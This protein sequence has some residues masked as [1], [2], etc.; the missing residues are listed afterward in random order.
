[1]TTKNNLCTQ[2][3]KNTAAPN[4]KMCSTC[5]EKSIK[6]NKKRLNFLLKQGLCTSCGKNPANAT[7]LLCSQCRSRQKEL[8][9]QRYSKRLSENLCIS[10]GSKLTDL[11]Y[12][13]CASCRVKQVAEVKS[14]KQCPEC[15][16]TRDI[17]SPSIRVC[18]DCWIKGRQR[19]LKANS[20]ARY[21]GNLEQIIDRDKECLIC[22]RPYGTRKNKVV[23]HHIDNNENNNDPS[24]LILLCRKCHLLATWWIECPNRAEALHF[25]LEHYPIAFSQDERLARQQTL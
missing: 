16:K 23:C 13:H 8:Y 9:E 17:N 14:N 20:K 1:M 4:R 12:R 22:K 19:R 5:L 11:R 3:H 24:N 21:G 10:C 6:H 2:C 25:L 15:S 7:R 18:S